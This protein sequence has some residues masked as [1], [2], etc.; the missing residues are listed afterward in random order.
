MQDVWMIM[1]GDT[2]VQG[3]PVPAEAFSHVRAL[4]SAAD[5]RIA[6]LEGLFGPTTQPER[7]DLPFKPRWRHV[8]PE[9][10]SAY[11]EAGFDLLCCASN[12]TYG[13]QHVLGTVDLLNR[14]GIAHAGIGRTLAEA[15]KPAIIERR[16]VRVGLLSRTSVFWPEGLAAT[17]TEPGA[18]VLRAHT[19][20]E[21]GRRALEMP[22]APPVV[23]TW[24]APDD[25][26]GLVERIKQLKREVD[27]A[28]V[29]CHWGV[30]SSPEPA[31]Y[32]Q[33]V[34]HAVIDAGADLVVGHHPHVLQPVEVYNGRPI[35]YSLGNFAFDWEKMQGRHLDGIVARVRIGRNG[36]DE[37]RI[38]PVQRNPAD[39][40]IRVCH[41]QN[42][43]PGR[44]IAQR[45][46]DLSGDRATFELEGGEIVVR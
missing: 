45:L 9:M 22:G 30:S 12:V 33:T 11:V 5:V 28:I 29:S 26:A 8:E 24:P 40:L 34:A 36:I 37:V 39:N 27:I 23:R 38:V 3:R 32:Q 42:D 16:G 4:L 44:A 7:P 18:A 31:E 19:A 6:H 25:L 13:R 43:E 15:E 46:R 2:N 1:A 20:Y 41:A 21:P 14:A 35:F 17:D 10:L